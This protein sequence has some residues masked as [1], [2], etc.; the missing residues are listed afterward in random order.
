MKNKIK[1]ICFDIDNVICKTNGNN[2]KLSK[3]DKTAIKT[4]N[5]LYEKGFYIKIFTAR[6]M[7]RNKENRKKVLKK[8][9]ETKN[10]LKRWGLKFNELIMCKPSYDVFVDDKAFGFSNKWK[11][12]FKKL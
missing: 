5:N 3:P 4:I 12:F 7:G 6:Y 2:Y 11:K 8:K 10:F 1:I 9:L